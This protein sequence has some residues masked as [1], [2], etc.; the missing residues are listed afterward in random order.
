M[1]PIRHYNIFPVTMTEQLAK[2]LGEDD[3]FGKPLW[4]SFRDFVDR[5]HT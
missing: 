1:G 3:K 4:E 5:I 2:Y